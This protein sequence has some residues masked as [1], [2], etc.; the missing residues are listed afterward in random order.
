MPHL[1]CYGELA[2][3]GEESISSFRFDLKCIRSSL[4]GSRLGLKKSPRRR[5]AR[6]EVL[7]LEARA[8]L[9]TTLAPRTAHDPFV[10]VTARANESRS[11]A[12]ANSARD[13]LVRPLP[14][15][16]PLARLGYYLTTHIENEQKLFGVQEP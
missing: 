3:R 5:S 4:V 1:P 13:Q 10:A 7:Q 6:L 16:P 8:L 15:I 12:R 14:S 11:V 2:A 9:S